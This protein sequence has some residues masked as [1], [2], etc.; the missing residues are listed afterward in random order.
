MKTLFIRTFLAVVLLGW[1]A[2]GFAQQWSD[3]QKD[4]WA[5]VESYN[6]AWNAS[7][8]DGFMSHF[9]ADYRGWHNGMDTPSNRDSV[10]RWVELIMASEKVLVSESTPL[11]I[12]IYGDTAIVHS[13]YAALVEHGNGQRKFERGRWTDILQRHDNRWLLIGDH[14]GPAD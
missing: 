8:L 10:R 3:A 6:E 11:S 4:V 12:Q 7:D 13:V 14:G 1:T 9:H 5:T 2:A